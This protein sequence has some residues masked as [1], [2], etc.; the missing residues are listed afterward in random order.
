MHQHIIQNTDF[1]KLVRNDQESS[2]HIIIG[3][4]LP[5]VSLSLTNARV[6]VFITRGREHEEAVQMKPAVLFS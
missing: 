2:S 5:Q 4:I 1:H 3:L 6:L